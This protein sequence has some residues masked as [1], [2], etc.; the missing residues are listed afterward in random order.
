MDKFMNF[1]AQSYTSYEKLLLPFDF[2]TWCFLLI[3]F[4]SAF[5]IIFIIDLMPV[6]LHSIVYGKGVKMPM[7]NVLRT[8]F[9]IAQARL[10]EGNFSRIILMSF[11][12][13]CL[14]IR[15]AYQGVFFELLTTDMRKPQP[16]TVDDLFSRNYTIFAANDALGPQHFVNFINKTK[17]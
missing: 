14:V 7:L 12:L 10:P 16:E 11:I 17:G 5:A 9:G 15:T 2:T 3:T 4:F 1:S 8:F 13:F 6:F